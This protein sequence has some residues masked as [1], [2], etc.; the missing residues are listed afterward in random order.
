MKIDIKQIAMTAG[1]VAL[2][3][4]L[5]RFIKHEYAEMKAEKEA[6]N[7]TPQPAAPEG[8]FD[9]FRNYPKMYWNYVNEGFMGFTASDEFMMLGGSKPVEF[10]N[11]AGHKIPVATDEP[12]F[13]YAS[14]QR[15]KLDRKG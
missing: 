12:N 13:A 3:V 14:G 10:A 15:K 4:V 11:A 7:A 8:V 9:R 5:F 1:A 2:G 6:K